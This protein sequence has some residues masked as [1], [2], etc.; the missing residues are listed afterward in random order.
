ML[1]TINNYQNNLGA[2]THVEAPYQTVSRGDIDDPTSISGIVRT[3]LNHLLNCIL[4]TQ[5][6]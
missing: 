5:E 6:D 1:P 3:L 4:A 2:L